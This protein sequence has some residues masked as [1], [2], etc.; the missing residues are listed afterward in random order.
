MG[1]NMDN[2]IVNLKREIAASGG[3]GGGT[4]DYS[5]LSN[6]PQINS[7]ELSGN[8]SLSDLGIIADNISYD[9]TTSG[10]IADTVQE[11][12]DELKT[13]IPSEVYFEDTV[14]LSTSAT[15]TVTFTEEEILSTSL[16]DL[17]ISVWGIIPD[18][19]VVSTGSCVITMPIVDTAVSVTVRIYVR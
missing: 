7:V 8:K 14:T 4:S 3:G 12:I 5:D 17:A 11:A 15:T 10:L 2:I 6:K 18:D 19:V 16:I 1:Y 13:D 9:N